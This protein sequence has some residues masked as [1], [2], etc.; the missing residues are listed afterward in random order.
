MTDQQLA[1]VEN[2]RAVRQRD[3]GRIH[4]F[5]QLGVQWR[6]EQTAAGQHA[7]QTLFIVD[8]I[9]IDDALT[10]TLGADVLQRLTHVELVIERSIILTGGMQDREMQVL[11]LGHGGFRARK[12]TDSLSQ[13]GFFTLR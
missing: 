8:H 1:G 13:L 5:H 11:G 9:E 6:R 2:G 12:V 4:Q 10:Q 7:D 3:D